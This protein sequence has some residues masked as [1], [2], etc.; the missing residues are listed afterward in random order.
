[1]GGTSCF[2]FAIMALVELVMTGVGESIWAGGDIP[3]CTLLCQK[4]KMREK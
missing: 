2:T 1:M 3:K 4:L